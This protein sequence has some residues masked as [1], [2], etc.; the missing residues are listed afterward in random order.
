MESIIFSNSLV[1]LLGFS[2]ISCSNNTD[3]DLYEQNELTNPDFIKSQM[4]GKWKYWGRFYVARNEWVSASE[5]SIY[6]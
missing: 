2:F 5:N 4:L 1:S 6:Y 3:S